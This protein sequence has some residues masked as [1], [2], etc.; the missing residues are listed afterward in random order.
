MGNIVDFYL[1]VYFEFWGLIDK[2]TM[3]LSEK[4]YETEMKDGKPGDVQEFLGDMLVPNDSS[5][6]MKII[7]EYLPG[8]K[9]NG[10]LKRGE[11]YGVYSILTRKGQRVGNF[12]H[13]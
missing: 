6:V 4:E 12:S 2:K 5:A 10:I 7:L 9:G 8:L 13:G 11:D 1:C 3:L